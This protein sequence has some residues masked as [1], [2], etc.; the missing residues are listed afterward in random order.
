[1]SSLRMSKLWAKVDKTRTEFKI[2]TFCS[3]KL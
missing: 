3:R 2:V 1:M